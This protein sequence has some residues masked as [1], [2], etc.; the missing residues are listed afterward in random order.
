ML[1]FVYFINKHLLESL[2][3]RFKEEE[4]FDME[5]KHFSKVWVVNTDRVFSE[6]DELLGAKRRFSA[7]SRGVFDY[8]SNVFMFSLFELF[9]RGVFKQD[10]KEGVGVDIKVFFSFREQHSEGV[11]DL[12]FSGREFL[13]KFLD[14]ACEVAEVG[15]C[16]GVFEQLR[17][18]QSKEGEDFGVLFVGFRGS[19]GIDKLEEPVNELRV[20]DVG[21]N[22]VVDEKVIQRDMESSRGLHHHNWFRQ[23]VEELKQL[24]ETFRRHGMI[25]RGNSFSLFIKNTEMEEFLRNINTDRVFHSATSLSR[26]FKSLTPAS[27][28]AGASV[29]Q[30]TYWELRDRGADSFGGLKAHKSW[31]PCPSLILPIHAVSCRYILN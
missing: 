13:L 1:L 23:G 22:I 9:S 5:D 10:V 11:F 4:F 24:R 6:L 14:E 29:A 3:L 7:Y 19:V 2:Y 20:D 15:V 8:G 17:I 27:R 25:T 16:R 31:S 21:I 28:V 18:G 30:P 12:S 26:D